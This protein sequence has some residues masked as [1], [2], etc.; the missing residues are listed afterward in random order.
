MRIFSYTGQFKRDIKNAEKRGKDMT[1]IKNVMQLLIDATPLPPALLD[2]PLRGKWQ[3]SRELH[4]EPDWL[5]V[6][7]IDDQEV[8]FERTGSHSDLFK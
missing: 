7:W 5:L 2:H 1:K 6:Y 3:P 4:I 8:R